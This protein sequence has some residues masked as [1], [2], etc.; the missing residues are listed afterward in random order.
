MG[1][2][3]DMSM[4]GAAG[5]WRG[6]GGGAAC[7]S[8]MLTF[9]SARLLLCALMAAAI[10]PPV[11]SPIRSIADCLMLSTLALATALAPFARLAPASAVMRPAL[12][13]AARNPPP[14][15]ALSPLPVWSLFSLA[16]L[17]VAR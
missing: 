5:A 7:R 16:L 9:V 8:G 14:L 11:V 2:L 17:S 10:L 13:A 4:F 3:F 15:A 1:C 6:I 12:A